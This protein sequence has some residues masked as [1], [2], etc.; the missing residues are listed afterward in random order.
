MSTKQKYTNEHSISYNFQK[1]N[2][3]INNFFI[4][5]LQLTVTIRKK[6]IFWYQEKN[7]LL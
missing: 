7:N 4:R 1:K 3:K 2:K 5:M 6:N